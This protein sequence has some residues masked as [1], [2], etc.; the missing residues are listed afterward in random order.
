MRG[1]IIDIF[2]I[3]EEHPVRI[4]LFD[5]EVDSVRLFDE[6]TPRSIE[7][8]K[9]QVFLPLD[10][11]GVGEALVFSYLSKALVF[12]DEPQRCEEALKRYFKEDVAH[13]KAALS[14]KEV[15]GQARKA[16]NKEI[17]CTLLKRKLTGFDT[18][19]DVAWQG[20]TMTTYQ[21]QIPIF[22]E[23]L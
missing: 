19:R 22:M 18:E 8:R 4:E 16:K 7:D 12:Y 20:H 2:P 1:D 21:R 13:K 10:G 9:S 17:V 3:N 23:D 15:I 11:T 5:D 14:W 6:D